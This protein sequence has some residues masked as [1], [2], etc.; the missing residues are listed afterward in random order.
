MPTDVAAP[1]ATYRVQLHRGFTF[2]DAGAIA[3]YLADLGISHLYCSPYLQARP[4]SMHGYD[5]VDHSRFSD[6]LG[7]SDGHGAMVG[8]LDDAGIGH[9]VDIVPN[10]MAIGEPANRWWWDVLRNGPSSEF[11]S[12]F[13]INWEPP[14]GKLRWMVHCPVL[15][16]HYGRVLERGEFKL[17]RRDGELVVTYYEHVM[18][19]SPASLAELA[20]DDPEA[21]IERANSDVSAM[22]E[23][24]ERQH[25]RLAYWKTAGQELNYRRF[26]AINELVALRIEHPE[27][28]RHVHELVLGLVRDGDLHGLRIDHIDGLLDPEDY[29]QRLRAEAPG[30]YVVVE[31]I[32]EP[33]EGL[34]PSWP[35]EGTTGYDYLNVAGGLMVDPAAEGPLTEVYGSVTGTI[36][37]LAE[38][39]REKKWLLMETE[40]ATDLDRLT[41]QFV[42]VCEGYPRHRDYTRSE[43]RAALGETIAAFPV[44][45]S[46]VRNE[47]ASAQDESVI[48]EAVELASKRRP[49]LET[50]LFGLLGDVLLMRTPNRVDRDLALRFQQT[51]GP[52]MAKGVED[53]LFYAFNR[54][55]PLNEVGGDPGRF[56]VGIDEFHEWNEGRAG[57]WPRAMLATSTHDTKRSEDVRA[58]MAL[59]SEIP[60]V[61][62]EKV[63]SW[64]ERNADL[65]TGDMPD[66]DMEYLLYQTLVGSWPLS[67]ERAVE[68][69]AKASKEAKVH[70]SWIDPNDAYDEALRSFIEGV[71]GDSDFVS[72]LEAFVAP[73]IDPGFVNSL[74]Q[75][76]LKLTA[77]GVPDV[78]QGQEVW[79]FSLVD[80]DNRRPVDYA[81]RRDL[82]D[83]VKGMSAE[84]AWAERA[85]GSPKLM[86]LHRALQLRSR[87]PVAFEGSYRALRAFGAAKDHV[88][89][90]ARSEEVVTVVPR[91][92][93]RLADGWDATGLSLPEGTWR[94]VV[95]GAERSGEIAV[96]E[97]LSTFPVALLEKAEA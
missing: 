72:D 87:R 4:G 5:V 35:V 85:S 37:D 6:D 46:Y 91:L 27:V 51:S 94:D 32:L 43:L 49:E 93:L 8:A 59:L 40:L 18:P 42:E 63:G 64:I 28:F 82:L 67:T 14:A 39:T 2:H 81:L 58:R 48:R 61:W 53:T 71:L 33:S 66:R 52:V 34:P 62:A 69:M 22:H 68:Y 29:L 15:G 60:E 89:A 13:D 95:S 86:L 57:P 3:A 79:D 20:G 78:Y 16:D 84:Q 19:V 74:A 1:R 92:T 38:M 73:L 96:S 83:R 56:G 41:D 54:F 23:L 50:E 7:G 17:E 24:L 80:P 31:K 9:I 97:L 30:A 65:R 45:R 76:L 90:F 12:H 25:Y 11:A 70:T 36:P 75:V 55:A 26:F 88:V 44:Y 77:P 10:H 21:F 47:R